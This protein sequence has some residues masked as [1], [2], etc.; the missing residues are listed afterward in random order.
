MG[1]F[2]LQ[3][4]LLLCISIGSAFAGNICD[5]SYSQVAPK[6]NFPHVH[7]RREEVIEGRK[8]PEGYE[9]HFNRQVLWLRQPPA[10]SPGER[11]ANP[12][13]LSAAF[14]PTVHQLILGQ[15]NQPDYTALATS[16]SENH[17][18]EFRTQGMVLVD[19]VRR[20]D[21][22]AGVV[23]A[24]GPETTGSY[25]SPQADRPVNVR[26]LL[27]NSGDPVIER[28][29][30]SAQPIVAQRLFVLEDGSVLFLMTHYLEDASRNHVLVDL[31]K[32]KAVFEFLDFN[33]GDLR[34]RME[35]EAMGV[36]PLG[37]HLAISAAN[38]PRLQKKDNPDS[39]DRVVVVLDLRDDTAHVVARE[40]PT[41]GG[42]TQRNLTGHFEFDDDAMALFG[43][44]HD[45]GPADFRG[46]LY[47]WSLDGL[48]PAVPEFSEQ[49]GQ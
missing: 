40:A 29:L 23:F 33:L 30:G 11:V 47:I 46:Q 27:T 10:G 12:V 35:L 2:I 26:T 48:F 37:T 6:A 31:T 22:L 32:R 19:G 21:A 45:G 17:R 14:N 18:A 28:L 44:D 5:G 20:H 41:A 15:Q 16:R 7:S 25:L 24:Y 39:R 43:Y 13:N 49:E 9:P 8:L 34:G 42:P 3:L 1:P 4:A 36:H 38:W